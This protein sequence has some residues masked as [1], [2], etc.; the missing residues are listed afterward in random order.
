MYELKIIRRVFVVIIYCVF[1]WNL[2]YIVFWICV[3]KKVIEI[4]FYNDMKKYVLW[5]FRSNNIVFFV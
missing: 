3:S 5:I 4:V 1:F 2:I